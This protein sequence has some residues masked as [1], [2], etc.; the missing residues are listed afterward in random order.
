[1][2]VPLPL[3]AFEY[4]HLFYARVDVVRRTGR[5]VGNGNF[6]VNIAENVFSLL[7][8]RLLVYFLRKI[9]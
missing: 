6:R 7:Y 5:S 3:T 1:M 2:S 4:L 8:E 9:T